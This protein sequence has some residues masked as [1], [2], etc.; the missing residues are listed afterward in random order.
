[1]GAF[2]SISGIIMNLQKKKDDG[3]REK[4]KILGRSKRTRRPH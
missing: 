1:M 3:S 2:F 4:K